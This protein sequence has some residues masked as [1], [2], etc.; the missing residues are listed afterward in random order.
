MN[1]I[2]KLKKRWGIHSTPQIIV[3]CIV[4]ALTGLCSAKLAAPLTELIGLHKET[5]SGWVYWPVRILLIFPL[6]QML[7]VFFGW[8]FGQFSFFWKFE[9]KMLKRIGLG[10]L[11]S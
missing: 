6:Y 4:F 10:F 8:I 5:V 3:I 2:Q 1:T 7:L 11:I 9:K